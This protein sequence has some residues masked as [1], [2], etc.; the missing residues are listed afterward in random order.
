MKKGIGR[1]LCVLLLLA[2]TG[3]GSRGTTPARALP[4]PSGVNEA[5]EAGMARSDNEAAERPGQTGDR[6][7]GGS[8]ESPAPEATQEAAPSPGGTDGIDIDLTALPATMAYSELFHMLVTPDESIGKTVKIR[9]MFAFYHD[10]T[11]DKYYFACLLSDA[12][13]CCVQGLEFIPTEEYAFPDD[14]P[15]KGEEITVVG[16]LDTYQDGDNT[17]CTL[18]DAEIIGD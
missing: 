2:L 13:A 9:G 3:C 6:A 18:R 17:Y 11:A 8:G 1:A 15:Q 7:P 4:P 10:E 5:L 16:V 12:T 14:F